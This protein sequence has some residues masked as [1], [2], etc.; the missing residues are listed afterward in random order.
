MNE[1]WIVCS[2]CMVPWIYSLALSARY[3]KYMTM[4]QLFAVFLV[5][6]FTFYGVIIY[7]PISAFDSLNAIAKQWMH[8]DSLY[9]ELYKKAKKGGKASVHP[10]KPDDP[11]A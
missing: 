5:S 9:K 2:I 4:P 6:P 3:Y 10:I 1:F 11:V 8:E 7:S